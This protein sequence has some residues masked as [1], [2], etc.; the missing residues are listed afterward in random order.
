[1]IK[2]NPSVAIRV[3]LTFHADEEYSI[4]A[5]KRKWDLNY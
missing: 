3:T 5:S 2:S 1:M 4:A